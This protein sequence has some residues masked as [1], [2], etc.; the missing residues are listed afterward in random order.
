VDY[1]WFGGVAPINEITVAPALEYLGSGRGLDLTG[2]TVGNFHIGGNFRFEIIPVVTLQIHPTLSN[3]VQLSWP[4]AAGDYKLHSGPTL[5]ALLQ[6]VPQLPEL[7]AGD[8][9]V[10]VPIQSSNQFFRLVLW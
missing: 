3:Y 10:T 6:P 5:D 7:I 8:H 2:Y 4:A 1:F 9:V